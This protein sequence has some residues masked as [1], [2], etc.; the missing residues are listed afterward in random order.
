MISKLCCKFTNVSITCKITLFNMSRCF[1]C[2]GPEASAHLYFTGY[3]EDKKQNPREGR[4]IINNSGKLLTV[5]CK[6]LKVTQ[7]R[8]TSLVGICKFL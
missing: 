1:R 5:L 2:S 6:R 7:V 4:G 8:N 3:C